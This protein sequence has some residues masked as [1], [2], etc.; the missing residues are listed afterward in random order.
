MDHST[1]TYEPFE[2]NFYKEHRDITALTSSQV[3]DLRTTLGIK[4]S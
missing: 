4:V 3:A 1:L 2:K